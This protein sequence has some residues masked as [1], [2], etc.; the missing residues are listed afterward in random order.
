MKLLPIHPFP[1]RMA[2][3]IVFKEL[4]GMAS[5]KTILDPMSGS[6]T[7]L[8]AAAELG[9]RA[10]GF[11]LDPL[12]VLMAKVWTTPFQTKRLISAAE[13][14]VMSARNSDEMYLP[15]IDDCEETAKY[16]S[17]WFCPKQ[18][19]PLRSLALALS[20]TSGVLADAM[21]IALSRIIVT[22]ERGASIAR[23]T[24]HSRPHRVFF[25][26][27]Y[28]VYDGFLQSVKRL[29]AR[30]SPDKLLGS[31]AVTAG[32]SRQLSNLGSGSVDVVIT[33]PPYLN[34]IDYLRGHRLAL[35]WLG[36]T[37]GDLR[38]LRSKSI[39]VESRAEKEMPK[40]V[41]KALLKRSG[42]LNELPVRQLG[43]VHHYAQDVLS[44]MQELMRI[45]KPKGQVLLVVG[46]SCL[47]G[48][49]I[50][51]ANINVAAAEMSGFRL[52]G[53]SERALPTSSR[54][55]P[56]PAANTAGSLANRMRTE[57]LLSFCHV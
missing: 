3:E 17:F 35:V 15:W 24:S 54:Y 9:H 42:T 2:P 11:D 47:S 57:T 40:S 45:T 22:K 6:G 51:N 12:A 38:A 49:S 26:N 10:I 56:M 29:A 34:A 48:V 7:V 28:E 18:E 39:G 8:R 25:D 23:D 19:K 44:F 5:P 16:V 55:L 27:D 52:V 14:L 21:K 1:A 33:S 50:S 41:L 32:D 37:I 31:A 4:A 53:R 46:N 30:L 20:R 43:M 36:Y 13:K